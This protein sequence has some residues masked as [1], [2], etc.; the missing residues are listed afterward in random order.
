MDD[1]DHG[2]FSKHQKRTYCVQFNVFRLL[3]SKL[4]AFED[5]HLFI[6]LK[7]DIK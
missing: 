2:A 3:S 6:C 5:T 7:E 4:Q 1:F